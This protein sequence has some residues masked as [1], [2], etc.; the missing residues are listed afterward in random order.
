METQT[1]NVN[2]KTIWVTSDPVHSYQTHNKAIRTVPNQY[3]GYYR[4]DPPSE[5]VP[6]NPLLQ[7][8]Q[9]KIFATPE[10]IIEHVRSL[11][12]NL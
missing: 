7:D 10:Q 4:Y 1:I 5:T 11:H 3:Y 2:G 6:C 12:E 8:G 9:P